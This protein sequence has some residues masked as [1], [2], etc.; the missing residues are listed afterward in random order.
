MPHGLVEGSFMELTDERIPEMGYNTNLCRAAA[1][2]SSS[3]EA[4][5]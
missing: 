3:T 5:T 2:P 4:V 1:N